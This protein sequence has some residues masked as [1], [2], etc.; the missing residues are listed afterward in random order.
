MHTNIPLMVPM[1]GPS[2]EAPSDRDLPGVTPVKTLLKEMTRMMLA[3]PWLLALTIFPN[4]ISPALAPLQAWLANEVLAE[5][6]KGGR[7]FALQELLTYVPYALAVF[8]GLALLQIFEKV[9]NRM[10]DDRLLIDVQRR[11]F[12]IRGVGC[13]GQQVAKA[14]NDAKNV[15]KI[16]DLA[17]KEIWVVLIGVPAVLLW[18][19]KLSPELLP[20]LVVTAFIPFLASLVF[21]QIIARLSLRGVV[22]VGNVSSAVAQG[23][24]R[25]L[26][27]EQEKLYRNR[28]KFEVTK[29]LSEVTSEFAFWLSLVLVLTLSLGGVWALLPEQLTAA[30][31]GVFLVNLKLLT[32]P[33]NAVTKMH[34]KVRESWPSVRRVLRPQEAAA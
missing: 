28:I 20:A 1:A 8:M 6:A 7:A 34:N 26:H 21:G 31:I 19:I 3:H 16:F 5:V 14:T 18:Q 4:I 27:T 12:E 17:Q 13:A 25:R 33:L 22:L 9:S 24:K 15:V 10:Y 29:Q 2:H 32:K 30:Q 11:W 23:D